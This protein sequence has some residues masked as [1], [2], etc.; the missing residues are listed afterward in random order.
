MGACL[1]LVHTG[2]ASIC[3]LLCI[4]FCHVI[5]YTESASVCIV[6]H[7]SQCTVRMSVLWLCHI[8]HRIRKHV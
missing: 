3:N 6:V 1:D 4:C 8:V 7:T 5:L 2:P